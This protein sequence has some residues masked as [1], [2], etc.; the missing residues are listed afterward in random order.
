MG[1]TVEEGNA[2]A[3]KF[4]DAFKAGF[5][6]NNHNETFGGLIAEKASWD[7]SDGLKACLFLFMYETCYTLCRFPLCW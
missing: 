4:V 7:W 5:A 1:I 6:K 3:A 2:F